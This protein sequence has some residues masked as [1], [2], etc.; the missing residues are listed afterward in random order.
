VSCLAVP[1]A[2]DPTGRRCRLVVVF[3][4]CSAVS[5]LVSASA[6]GQSY[7]A[8]C[9]IERLTT[10]P[11]ARNTVGALGNP[12][13][14]LNDSEIAKTSECLSSALDRALAPVRDAAVARTKS[15][16]A[17]SSGYRASEHGTYLQVFANPQAA[18]S[19]ALYEDGAR[20]DVGSTI[21]K[22]AFR[23]EIDGRTRPYRVCIK[24]RWLARLA[25][26]KMSAFGS[27]QSVIKPP[28]LRISFSLFRLNTDFN[29]SM[30]RT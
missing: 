27:A 12:P 2:S 21:V 14:H 6:N 19:Y 10:T 22:R 23:V 13:E 4:C 1:R 24:E 15:W 5:S 20:M 25:D 16:T 9:R 3:L 29:S 30:G 8:E 26:D 7:S 18:G 17:M 28:A 11:A